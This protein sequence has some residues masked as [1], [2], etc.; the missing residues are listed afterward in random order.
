MRNPPE[1]DPSIEATS[2]GSARRLATGCFAVLAMLLLACGAAGTSISAPAPG[3]AIDPERAAQYFQEAQA[4]SRQDAGRLWGVPIYGPMILVDPA[5]HAAVANQADAEGRLEKS[6]KV[7]V[8]KVPPNVM[9]ANTAMDWGGVH[10]T[11]MMWPLPEDF[12]ARARLMMH[13][14][15]HRIQDEI[16][17]PGASPVNA[18]LESRE[19]RI[20]MLLEWRA[21][22]VALEENGAERKQALQDALLFRAYRQSLFPKAAEEER[23]LEMNEGLAEYTGVKLSTHSIP[24]MTMLAA[25]DLRQAPD[26][27]GLARSFAYVS[28]PAY[29]ALLDSS[30]IDWR[31]QVKTIRDF[32]ALCLTAYNL[33]PVSPSAEQALTRAQAYHGQEVIARETERDKVSQERV[34]KFREKFITGPVLIL[35]LGRA[36]RYTFNPNQTLPLDDTNTIYLSSHFT[37]D[38]GILDAPGGVLFVRQ[39]EWR[40]QVPAPAKLDATPL[41]GDGWSLTLQKGWVIAPGDRAGDYVLKHDN[42]QR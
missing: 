38:W 1:F 27:A 3:Q 2:R 33:G 10:W 39:G 37:D 6:E 14:C 42:G 29:G 35:P 26:R 8:G 17:L 32:A 41:Q 20:W 31:S 15:F 30:G 9:A 18:H 16:G 22:E 21:L 40:I 7:F 19:G 34:A 13:E 11:M 25:R 5:T 28:G 36:S 12:D 24:E 23:G 4:L